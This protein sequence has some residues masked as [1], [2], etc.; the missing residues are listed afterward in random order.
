ME[1]KMRL[2]SL[3][4]IVAERLIG[5]KTSVVVAGTHGKTTTTAMV[6][7]VLEC[8]GLNPGF[9][10]GGVPGNF[11]VSCRPGS[12]DVFVTE[13]DEYDSAFWDKRSK[14]LHYKPD[15]AIVNNLEFDHADIFDTLAAIIKQFT[16]F[17]RLVPRNGLILANGDEEN[18]AEVL[19][20][21]VSPVQTFGFS[22]GCHWRVTDSSE[23]ESG[24]YF[25]VEKGGEFFG[26]FHSTVT[27][28]F[29]VLNMLVAIATAN[30]LGI[31]TEK[32]GDATSTYIAP[33][34]RMQELGTWRGAKVIDDFGHHPTAILA[35]ISA[36]KAKYPNKRVIACFEPRSNTTTRAFFQQEIVDC[37]TDAS[38]VALGALD[39]PD[40]YSESERLN[41]NLIVSKLEQQGKSA[42]AISLEQGREQ[43]WGKHI[44][45][46]LEAHVTENDLLVF[47]SNGDFGGLRK[48]VLEQIL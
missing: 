10:I 27:G 30:R 42:Y 28:K 31:S 7:H 20:G 26:Q 46:W 34:R 25:S 17:V 29:N 13:G 41:V 2:S 18:V 22:E 14:F 39:R 8:G 44:F 3:P 24:T 9:L 19:K 35:T 6:A 48:L 5:Q 47:F 45:S 36:L 1:N 12:G 37:F 38:V 16:L 32:T 40:R 21:A 15:I 4:E 43:Q 33:K 23:S 11:D